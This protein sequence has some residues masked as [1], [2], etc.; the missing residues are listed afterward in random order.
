MTKKEAFLGFIFIVILI[1][2]ANFITGC[3]YQ[4]FDTNWNYNKAII[5]T[6]EGIITVDVAS[7]RDYEDDD[8]IQVT[9]TDGTT[10]LVH[11]ANVTLIDK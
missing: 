5:N 2:V 3:N 10:Y 7:W 9:T 6:Q 8:Q 11:S 4:A 1:V